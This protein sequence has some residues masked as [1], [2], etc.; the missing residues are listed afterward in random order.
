MSP[1]KAAEP[2]KIS[3]GGD[4]THMVPRNHVLHGGRDPQMGKGTLGGLVS[5]AS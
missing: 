1:A 4:Q 5:D 2:I 3:F